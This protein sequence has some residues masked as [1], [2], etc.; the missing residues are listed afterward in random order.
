[1]TRVL[2]EILDNLLNQKNNEKL[3]ALELSKEWS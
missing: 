2:L 3:N 1:M